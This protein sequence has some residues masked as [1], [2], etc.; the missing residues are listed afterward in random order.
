MTVRARA[1]LAVEQIAQVHA[2]M[3]GGG[4]LAGAA[5][6]VRVDHHAIFLPLLTG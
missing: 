4:Q 6:H 5:V 3:T 1:R 2:V